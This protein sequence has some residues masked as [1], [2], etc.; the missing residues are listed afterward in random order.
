MELHYITSLFVIGA[1]AAAVVAA[2]VAS[3]AG[4]DTR[5]D[6]VVIDTNPGNTE[7][8]VSPPAASEA[9]S[10]GQF[11]SPAPFLGD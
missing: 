5:P 6:R 9:R 11:S 10:Y 3:A 2:P 8:Q 7:I 4:A 1:A